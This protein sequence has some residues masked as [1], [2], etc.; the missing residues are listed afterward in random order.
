MLSFTVAQA[1]SIDSMDDWLYKFGLCGHP[2]AFASPSKKLGNSLEKS[3]K[4]SKGVPT[5]PTGSPLPMGCTVCEER[6]NFVRRRH[7]CKSCG[8]TVCAPCSKTKA[9][10][11]VNSQHQPQSLRLVLFSSSLSTCPLQFFMACLLLCCANCVF[12]MYPV[13]CRPR[14]DWR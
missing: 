13:T 8:R 9:M 6:F 11:Q 1:S 2:D 14:V 7:Q 4:P 12:A 3:E 10:L 5:G